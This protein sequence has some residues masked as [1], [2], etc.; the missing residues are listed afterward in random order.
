MNGSDGWFRRRRRVR[1]SAD[2]DG[3]GGKNR[4]AESQAKEGRRPPLAVERD[5]ELL[6]HGLPLRD[7]VE[8]RR[9]AFLV[10]LN[11]RQHAQARPPRRPRCEVELWVSLE[12][13][14][15]SPLSTVAEKYAS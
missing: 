13:V 5:R 15:R 11:L 8:A 12:R 9:D 10:R 7:G 1:I 6:E 4:V 3:S 2:G 14:G